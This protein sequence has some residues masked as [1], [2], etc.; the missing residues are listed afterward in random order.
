MI[1]WSAVCKECG[2]KEPLFETKDKPTAWEVEEILL[3]KGFNKTR[4]PTNLF[5]HY[6]RPCK[7][8][9]FIMEFTRVDE[10]KFE[11]ELG[12]VVYIK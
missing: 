4:S 8:C 10:F 2:S 9:G 7:S 3:S 1:K 6:D 11:D 12:N 5:S